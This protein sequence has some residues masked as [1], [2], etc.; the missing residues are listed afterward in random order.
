MNK[1]RRMEIF[2][3][4]VEA[5]QLT[6]ASEILYLS[7]SAVSH[8]LNNLE[9]YL[10]LKLLNRTS[11]SWQLTEAGQTYYS[12]C[13]K[14]IADIELMEDGVRLENQNLS[15]LIRISAPDTF[16]SYTLAPILS[17]FMDIHPNIVIDLN[18]TDRFVDLIEERVDLAFRTGDITDQNLE[19]HRLGEARMMICASPKY[20]EKYGEPTTY[21][22][23]KNHRCIRY[24]RSPVW[25]LSKEGRQYEFTPKDHLLT[26]SGESMREFCVRGQGIACFPSSLGEFAVKKGRLVEILTNYDLGAMPV[27]VI[28]LKKSHTPLRVLRLFEFIEEEF[29]TRK[30]DIAEFIAP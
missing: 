7:K 19:V 11:R 15:G 30:R 18:L 8:A 14:I 29:G 28:R 17:K 1:F 9:D 3:A 10:N 16:G 4:V 21:A 2:V 13:K 24:T 20:L 26:D 6:R 22:G 5:G 27:Q 23:L 12:Q 25:R